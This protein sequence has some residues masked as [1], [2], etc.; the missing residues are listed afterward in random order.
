[1]RTIVFHVYRGVPVAR[2]WRRQQSGKSGRLEYE[3]DKNLTEAFRIA[4]NEEL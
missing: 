3:E 4:G 2:G 1:M